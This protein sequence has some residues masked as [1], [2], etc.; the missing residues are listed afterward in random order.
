MADLAKVKSFIAWDAASCMKDSPP[1]PKPKKVKL[2][3][4]VMGKKV[5]AP[6]RTVK[7]NA[8][9]VLKI[10]P[11]ES[12]SKPD[13]STQEKFYRFGQ[14]EPTTSWLAALADTP[15]SSLTDRRFELG[16]T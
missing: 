12:Q 8:S 7:L 6:E 9:P 15:S 5:G 1:A 11:Y 14:L 2:P 3:A 4:A 10:Q 16:L 13:I